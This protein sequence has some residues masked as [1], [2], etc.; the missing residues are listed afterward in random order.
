[1]IHRFISSR[2]PR[3]GRTI[4]LVSAAAGASACADGPNGPRRAQPDEIPEQVAI[5]E[6]TT[7][8][9][10]SLSR[11]RTA[12]AVRAFHMS[13]RPTSVA[14]FRQCVAA[15]ACSRPAEDACILAGQPNALRGPT[16][17]AEGSD[18]L[19]MT[20]LGIAQARAYCAWVGG[21]LPTI[22]QWL[23]AARGRAVA[24]YPWGNALPQCEQRPEVLRQPLGEP[25]GVSVD[26]SFAVGRHVAGASPFGVEDILLAPGELIGPLPDSPTAACAPPFQACVAYGLRPGTIDSVE[27]LAT[28][29]PDHRERSRRAY[30]F[31]CAFAGDSK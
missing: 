9:G 24:R 8:Y 10:F 15:G 14:Q 29:G 27:G 30:A 13:K 18:E 3:F 28:D 19:P 31:R 1:M 20:C 22:G 25:C 5:E 11:P 7:T 26:P 16:Y 4:V 6:G 2:M 17:E 21:A 23:T 12:L